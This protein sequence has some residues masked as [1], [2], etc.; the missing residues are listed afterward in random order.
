MIKVKLLFIGAGTANLIA[1][2]RLFDERKEDFLILE[3]GKKL[4]ERICP[5]ERNYTCLFCE[6]ECQVITGVGGSNALHGNKLCY[7][8]ASNKVI[9][10]FSVNEI[11]QAFDYLQTIASPYFDRQL[12]LSEE[13]QTP[14]KYNS[15]VF[16]A[17]HF[18]EMI[19]Q[20]S[21]RIKTFIVTN[22]EVCTISCKR[23]VYYVETVS[24]ALYS[25]KE[26]VLGTGRSSC[27]FLKDLFDHMKIKY[28][29]QTADA[30]IRIET[31]K[32]NFSP[33]YYY[34]NDPKFKYQF[35][36]LGRGRTFCAHNQGKVIPVRFGQS[37]YADGAFTDIF[38]LKNNI[39]L[40]IRGLTPLHDGEL[41]AWCYKINAYR[42]NS[43]I[44]G[45]VDINHPS[46]VKNIMDVIPC[47]PK[48][49]Y[50]VMMQSLLYELLYGTGSILVKQP[51][52]EQKMTIYG[53]AIDRYWVK[54]NLTQDFLVPGYAG[55]YILG[56]AS[57]ISR[58]FIQAMFTGAGWA[59]RYVNNS[60]KIKNS[61][62]SWLSLV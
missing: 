33:R 22:N 47:F 2:N 62:K 18:R 4:S 58:G 52:I 39:A 13:Y 3:K 38:G 56:D 44:L 28:K 7:F 19:N 42:N 45:D 34:Q 5:G 40:M 55:L 12:N 21:S 36:G 27:Q 24:G 16:N 37:F 6:P 32:D 54:P 35:P 59:N 60:S 57:G 10:N 17:T 46:L 53:P 25:A 31:H 49:E 41:E 1:A 9:N 14:K 48:T 15:D 43:L 51:G 8:P 50:K 61:V 30:G 23:G 11:K 29:K 20:L 26:V